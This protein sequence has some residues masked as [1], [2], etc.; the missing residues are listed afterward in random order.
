M[1]KYNI[2]NLHHKFKDHPTFQYY[3]SHGYEQTIVSIRK[4][5]DIPFYFELNPNELV[6][7]ENFRN[8]RYNGK[9][10]SIKNYSNDNLIETERVSWETELI[11]Q[12]YNVSL[13]TLFGKIYFKKM[14]YN[15]MNEIIERISTK[16]L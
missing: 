1:E 8:E 16:N 4:N 9:F 11:F 6:L 13:T 3:E 10:V 12:F 2:F 15:Q 14:K 5:I 7:I